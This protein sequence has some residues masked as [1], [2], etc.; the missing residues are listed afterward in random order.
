MAAATGHTYVLVP[1]GHHSAFPIVLISADTDAGCGITG[2]ADCS[3]YTLNG[4]LGGEPSVQGSSWV[5]A[6]GVG[7]I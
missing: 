4:R 1:T 3:P 2:E 6:G 5:R 7:V